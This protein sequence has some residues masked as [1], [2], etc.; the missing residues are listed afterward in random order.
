MY[1]IIKKEFDRIVKE[2]GLES[3]K[4]VIRAAALSTEEAIGN[5]EDK[6]YPLITG[7]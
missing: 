3:E 1:N 5:P 7:R 2:N 6:D 4:M